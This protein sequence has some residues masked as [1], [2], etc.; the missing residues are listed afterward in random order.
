MGKSDTGLTRRQLLFGLGTV[1]KERVWQEDAPEQESPPQQTTG[2]DSRSALQ[3][4]LHRAR[5]AVDASDPAAAVPLYREYLGSSSEDMTARTELGICLYALK[6]YNQ[7]R[8][9]FERVLRIK[10]S[11]DHVTLYLGLSLL[12]K[13]KVDKALKAWATYRGD[14]PLKPLLQEQITL[15]GREPDSADQAAAA[16]EAF[17]HQ[18]NVVPFVASQPQTAPGS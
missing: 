9:E 1:W 3:E 15:L 10:K 6:Q 4:I 14:D 2:N 17:M 18:A 16:V 5:M 7:A 12:R 8:V 13:N 11:D